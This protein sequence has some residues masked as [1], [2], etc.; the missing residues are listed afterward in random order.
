MESDFLIYRQECLLQ[1]SESRLF[2]QIQV[3]DVQKRYRRKVV[4]LYVPTEV[5]GCREDDRSLGVKAFKR[6]IACFKV[7]QRPIPVTSE[8]QNCFYCNVQF[9]WLHQQ[10]HCHKCGS[11]FCA[12]CSNYFIR[13]PDFA[14][15]GRVR[16]CRPCIERMYT[17]RQKL[18]QKGSMS[19]NE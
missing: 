1:S 19:P 8:V 11:A 15:K 2:I 3:Q 10:K 12:Q 9:S 5:D 16:C 7:C 4:D 13:L 6:W 17:S 18:N 14:Y